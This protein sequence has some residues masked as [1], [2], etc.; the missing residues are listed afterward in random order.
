M[1]YYIGSDR[2]LS[3]FHYNKDVDSVF[4]VTENRGDCHGTNWERICNVKSLET[5]RVRRIF[6]PEK[7]V[8]Q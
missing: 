8:E 7:H 2:I 1:L 4:C 5:E 3:T 6:A